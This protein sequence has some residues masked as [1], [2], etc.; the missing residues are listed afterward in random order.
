MTE[1]NLNHF[2]N[3]IAA[4]VGCLPEGIEP[5]AIARALV[6][7][8]SSSGRCDVAAIATACNAS[9]DALNFS[10]LSDR[11]IR[12]LQAFRV[13]LDL[14]ADGLIGLSGQGIKPLTVAEIFAQ[15]A[16]ALAADENETIARILGDAAS[17][18][19]APGDV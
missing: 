3:A 7:G 17:L 19:P 15:Q 13:T 16:A 9:L 4:A 8:A 12:A 5:A 11:Q 18:L 2:H 1:R 10:G 6:D 14:L